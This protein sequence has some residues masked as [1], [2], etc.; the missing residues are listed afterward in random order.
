MNF[1][2]YSQYNALQ[3]NISICVLVIYFILIPTAKNN[4]LFLT[5]IDTLVTE[6]ANRKPR[7]YYK[8]SP[9]VLTYTS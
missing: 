8:T 9:H 3:W 2:F 7:F 5:R 4:V 6:L 1:S